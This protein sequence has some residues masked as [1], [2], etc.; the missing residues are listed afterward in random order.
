VRL[1]EGNQ[2]FSLYSNSWAAVASANIGPL[3]D[4]SI[5]ADIYM[6]PRVSGETAGAGFYLRTVN[7]NTYHL[8]GGYAIKFQ[9]DSDKIVVWKKVSPDI[10]LGEAP[11]EF[12]FGTWYKVKAS[13]SGDTYGQLTVQLFVNDMTTPVLEVIDD[14]TGWNSYSGNTAGYT[15]L[16]GYRSGVIY[17]DNIKI[18]ELAPTI[19]VAPDTLSLKGKGKWITAYIELPAGYDVADI[20]ASTILLNDT[21]PAVTDTKYAFVT[22]AAKYIT[23]NDKDGILERMV[24]FDRSAVSAILVVGDEIEITVTGDIAGTPFEGT[25]TIKVK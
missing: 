7:K 18:Y 13:V 6:M 4:Y 15:S 21:V 16:S 9:P 24:K 1:F 12:D 17:Y 23:D 20:D 10:L 8:R 2:V 22:D 3:L 19:D 14:G 5:E 11:Y 25:D